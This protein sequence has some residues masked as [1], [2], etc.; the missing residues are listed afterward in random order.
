[1]KE[2]V[3]TD[4]TPLS[5]VFL[6]QLNRHTGEKLSGTAEELFTKLSKRVQSA[7]IADLKGT[8]YCDTEHFMYRMEKEGEKKYTMENKQ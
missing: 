8:G 1:M 2:S 4:A 7:L 3:I 6:V 5:A